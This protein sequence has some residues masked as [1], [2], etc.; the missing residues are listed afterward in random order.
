MY[1]KH[2][3]KEKRFID[4]SS[5][6]I[7]LENFE[8]KFCEILHHIASILNKINNILFSWQVSRSPLSEFSGSFLVFWQHC[9]NYMLQILPL[10]SALIKNN[11]KGEGGF[12]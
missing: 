1:F 3:N 12:S 6:F 4:L 8:D 11:A 2:H 5:N 9:G 10:I 7:K